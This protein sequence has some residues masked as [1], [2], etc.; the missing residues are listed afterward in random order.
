MKQ[1]NKD[2]ARHLLAELRYQT[3]PGEHTMA[4]CGT[5]GNSAARGGRMCEHCIMREMVSMGADVV[6]LSR[7]FNRLLSANYLQESILSDIDTQ[8][9]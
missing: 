3:S 8:H 9:K 2:R 5:C 1:T 4:A 7:F 6:A